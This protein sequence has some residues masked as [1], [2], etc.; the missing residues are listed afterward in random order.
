METSFAPIAL[1]LFFAF[2]GGFIMHRLRQPTLVG[3]ILVGALA[4]PTLFHGDA[5]IIHILSE[6]AL[7]LLMFMLGLE[8]E[9]K[10]FRRS[11]KPAVVV[12]ALQI[13]LSLDVMLGV[14]MLFSW[15]M[16][17]GILLGFVV[18]L[19]STAVAVSVLHTLCETGSTPWRLAMGTLVAQ[20][21]AVIPI[22]LVI[23]AL[24]AHGVDS[25]GFARLMLAFGVIGVS[26]FGIFELHKHPRWVVRF[27]RLLTTGKSQPVVAGLA[28]AFGAAS[29]SSTLGIGSAYGA[30]AVGLLAGNVG[31]IGASYRKAVHSIH[32][33]LM[34]TFFLSVGFLL[35]ISFFIRHWLEILVVVGLALFLKTVVNYTILKTILGLPRRTALILGATLGQIGEFSFVLVALGL[36]SGFVE[37]G[38][39]QFILAVIAL[40]LACSPLLLQG[41]QKLLRVHDTVRGSV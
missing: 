15:S 4:G 12:T 3:Y 16:Q 26:L 28:L 39:Y 14:G 6:L 37:K 31:T 9:I 40:S 34:M 41:I 33:L 21:L 11:V 19:S 17:F 8:L 35:D 10:T 2:L 24:G 32:D 18:A 7:V 27:E 38:E 20:D 30:F 23:S 22:L 25:G 13:F 36:E 5:P 29:L 1:V